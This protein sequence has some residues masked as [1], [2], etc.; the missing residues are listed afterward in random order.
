MPLA[1]NLT[2]YYTLDETGGTAVRADGVGSV[3]LPVITSGNVGD[4]VGQISNALRCNDVNDSFGGGSLQNQGAC[5]GIGLPGGAIFEVNDF[6]FSF[7]CRINADNQFNML[8]TRQGA[9]VAF[10]WTCFATPGG[11]P[12]GNERY[13]FVGTGWDLL[14]PA[15][16]PSNS[17]QFVTITREINGPANIYINGVLAANLPDSGSQDLTAGSAQD[18]LTIGGRALNGYTALECHDGWIDE[19]GFWTRA[20]T[21]SE[22]GLLYN[23][24]M[25]LPL[26]QIIAGTPLTVSSALRGPEMKF[27][28]DNPEPRGETWL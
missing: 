20:I 26:N 6:S 28:R 2:A 18:G 22:V 5:V 8:I 27:K 24:G 7:W 9:A 16:F 23:G 12:A 13:R 25:G 1:D 14:T 21:G 15:F 4:E 19:V 11:A 17:V 3:D 10:A